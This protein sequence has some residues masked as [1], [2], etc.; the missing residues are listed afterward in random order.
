MVGTGEIVRELCE[1]NNVCHFYHK[2]YVLSLIKSGLRN[3]TQRNLQCVE[4]ASLPETTH[5]RIPAD[6]QLIKRVRL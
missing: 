1:I 4:E 6:I 2:Q 5:G 3:L